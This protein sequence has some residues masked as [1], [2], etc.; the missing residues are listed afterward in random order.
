MRITFVLS[1]YPWRPMGAFR[2]V[3]EYSNHLA[4]RGHEVTAVHPRRLKDEEDLWCPRGALQRLR[5]TARRA[6]DT[7]LTPG[8]SWCRLDP[9]VRTLFVPEPTARFVPDADAIIAGAWGT[10]PYVLRLPE[11]KGEKFHL[12]QGYAAKYGLPKPWV[13]TV[14]RAAVHNVFISSWQVEI[15]EQLGSEDFALIP[16]GIDHSLFR[17][18]APIEPRPKTVAML[19]AAGQSK[20]AKDGLGA[21]QIAKQAHPDLK[22][23]LFGT[24]P[25]PQQ[26]PAWIEYLRDPPQER[27]VQ[28]VYNSSRIFLCPSWTEGFALPPL[29]A[30]ACGCAVVTTDCGGNRDYALHEGNALVSPPR[31]PESLAQNLLRVLDNDALRVRLASAGVERA[32]EFTWERSTNLLEEFVIGRL[33]G[34]ATGATMASSATPTLGPGEPPSMPAMGPLPEA[35]QVRRDR[36][37]STADDSGASGLRQ[38]ITRTWARLR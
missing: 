7:V 19:F 17:L 26:I 37:S 38:F 14:W 27:L 28:E 23:I 11:R 2:V 31:D 18:T 13:D 10:A 9:R 21:M 8:M 1:G 3:Y 32:R 25:R 12:I 35:A 34:H 4:A 5:A 24:Y 30:M 29:E 20:G 16:N 22:C 15:A 36:D 6:R 33:K